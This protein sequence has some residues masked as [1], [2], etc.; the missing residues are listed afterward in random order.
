MDKISQLAIK[1]GVSRTTVMNV[2]KRIHEIE[3]GNTYRY[4]TEEEVA[5]RKQ[6]YKKSGRP[7]KYEFEEKE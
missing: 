2:V 7:R 1:C 4:P 3:G 5:N 6:F